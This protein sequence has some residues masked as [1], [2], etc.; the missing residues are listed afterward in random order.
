MRLMAITIGGK[1]SP[2]SLVDSTLSSPYFNKFIYARYS[3]VMVLV[4]R[5]SSETANRL[6]P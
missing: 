4:E 2:V 6:Y 1:F 5:Y 3:I